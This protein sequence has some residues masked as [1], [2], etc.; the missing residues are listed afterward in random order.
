MPKSPALLKIDPSNIGSHHYLNPDHQCCFFYEYTAKHGFAF[1]VGN[2]FISNLKKPVSRRDRPE[3]RHKE[4]AIQKGGKLLRQVLER[5]PKVTSNA[6]LCAIPPSK[7]VGDPDYD[8]RMTQ[9]VRLGCEGTSAEARDLIAQ[10]VNYEAC[11]TQASGQ[12]QRPAELLANYSII[13]PPPRGVVILIDDVL[14]TG[15]HFVAARDFILRHYPDRRVIGI[16]MARR[17]F[18][19][20][21]DDFEDL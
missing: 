7:V 21:A 1:S 5:N 4:A 11:H 6:T 13:P 15:A 14:T 18:S 9:I 3:Y 19:D 10:R 8:D 17:V 20:I 2:Q 16:F 12:R